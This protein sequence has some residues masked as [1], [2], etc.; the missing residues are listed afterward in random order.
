MNLNNR[1]ALVWSKCGM[2]RD[3]ARVGRATF[4]VLVCQIGDISHS[5]LFTRTCSEKS[6]FS[7]SF[8]NWAILHAMAYRLHVY[9]L[10]VA[11]FC[12]Q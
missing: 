4:L 1:S 7:S 6:L 8:K 9:C 5:D 3:A 12:F 10:R 2:R 11:E